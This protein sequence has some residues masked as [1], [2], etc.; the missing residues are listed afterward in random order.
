MTLTME[1]ETQTN[2]K[3]AGFWLR[4]W[5]SIIDCIILSVISTILFFFIGIL[6]IFV[7]LLYFVV[8]ESSKMQGTFGKK[9]LDLKVTD[10]IGNRITFGR[11]FGRYLGKYIS[12]LILFIGYI[13]VGWTEKKQGLHDKMAGTLVIVDR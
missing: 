12:G 11:A 8:L 3:Y 7:S 6:V 1:N 9:A 10:R 5:A 2:P 4:F 13:M